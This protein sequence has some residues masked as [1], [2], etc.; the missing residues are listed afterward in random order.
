[1]IKVCTYCGEEFD[2]S[3]RNVKRCPACRDKAFHEYQRQYRDE[4]REQRNERS[5]R[6]RAERRRKNQRPLTIGETKRLLF[7]LKNAWHAGW[8]LAD[9]GGK[10]FLTEEQLAAV[11]TKY[12]A[13]KTTLY[14]QREQKFRDAAEQFIKLYQGYRKHHD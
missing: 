12:P 7:L 8:L 11:E 6:Y 1:M 13:H 5:R 3:A 4:H 9:S 2:T 14:R 10:T